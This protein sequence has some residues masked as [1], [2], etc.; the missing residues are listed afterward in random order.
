MR[1]YTWNEANSVCLRLNIRRS[2]YLFNLPQADQSQTSN[3]LNAHWLPMI[4]SPP[5]VS[6]SKGSVFRGFVAQFQAGEG[7]RSTE[8][9]VRQKSSP[10]VRTATR[11][12]PSGY[13]L[14]TKCIK[15]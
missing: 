5:D 3:H 8:E 4:L 9:G 10:R 7:L 12:N 1:R 11:M 14:T 15:R 13:G 2:L 6:E